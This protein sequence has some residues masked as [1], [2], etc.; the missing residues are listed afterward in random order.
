LQADNPMRSL[1]ARCLC[2]CGLCASRLSMGGSS[3]PLHC[4]R[5]RLRENHPSDAKGRRLREN[6][7]CPASGGRDR[8]CQAPPARR[9]GRCRGEGG[10]KPAVCG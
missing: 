7:R 9:A 8:R 4:A 2:A 5:R 10:A 6:G 3:A 1:A